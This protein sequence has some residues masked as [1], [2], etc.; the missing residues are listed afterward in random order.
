[1]AYQEPGNPVS[2]IKTSDSSDAS[3]VQLS[4]EPK[5]LT[6]EEKEAV[7]YRLLREYTEFLETKYDVQLV[8]RTSQR[9][10]S[11]AKLQPSNGVSTD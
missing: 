7:A 4:G 5:P 9:F 6:P 3:G 8:S 1:M 2:G 10:I 11:K